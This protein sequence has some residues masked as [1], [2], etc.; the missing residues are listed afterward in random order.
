MFGIQISDYDAGRVVVE[1]SVESGGIVCEFSV[2]Q[3]V[4]ISDFAVR[5]ACPKG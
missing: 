5:R 2:S 4:S 1:E 3:S